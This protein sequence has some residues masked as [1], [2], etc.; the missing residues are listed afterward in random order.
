M[1]MESWPDNPISVGLSHSAHFYSPLFETREYADGTFIAEPGD[2]ATTV[3]Y[4][5]EGEVILR[6][7]LGPSE[8][9]SA[10]ETEIDDVCPLPLIYIFPTFLSRKKG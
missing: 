4:V 5:Q 8:N 7:A 3:F 9:A 2:P 1:L 10:S 6:E